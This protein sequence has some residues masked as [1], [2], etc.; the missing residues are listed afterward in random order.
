ML[1]TGEARLYK[2]KFMFQ[3]YATLTEYDP[4]VCISLKAK[5]LFFI[6]TKLFHST[7]KWITHGEPTENTGY[8]PKGK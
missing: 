7:K 6:G 5:L 8:T 2:L 3:T 1:S 4:V